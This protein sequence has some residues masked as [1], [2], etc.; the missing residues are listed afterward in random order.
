MTMMHSLTVCSTTTGLSRGSRDQNFEKK[1]SL[2]FGQINFR[3]SQ[4]ISN[5]FD[6]ALKSYLKKFKLEGLLGPRAVGLME[7]TTI[8]ST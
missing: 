7:T 1:F 4:K 6:N 8:N 5:R 3:K 2:K